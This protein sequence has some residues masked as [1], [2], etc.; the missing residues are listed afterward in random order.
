LW[1]IS[2]KKKALSR[3]G[4]SAGSVGGVE[5]ATG[6]A[7]RTVRSRSEKETESKTEHQEEEM[8]EAFTMDG[9]D[10]YRRRRGST[11]GRRCVRFKRTSAG[12]RCAKFSG[13]RRK[14]RSRRS[15]RGLKGV[16]VLPRGS[17][18]E[19]YR[20][21]PSGKR[22][23]VKYKVPRDWQM[24]YRPVRGR[25]GYKPLRRYGY[26]G[27]VPRAGMKPGG[28]AMQSRKAI[29]S[30][31]KAGYY[32]TPYSGLGRSRRGRK[33]VRFKR[34]PAGRR[35]AKFSGTAKRRK[36]TRRRGSTAG[37]KCV[38]FKRTSAGRRC[39]KFGTGRKSPARRR[40]RSSKGRRCVRFK[41]T[42]AGRRCAKFN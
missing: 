41:R 24:L 34:T 14:T 2:I 16:G 4:G 15:T 18:C 9:F 5:S 17:V 39:A 11:K 33:C 19:R 29:S 3:V 10:G 35:C 8:I 20:K 36:S 40:R 31:R 27:K 13:S 38:R 1:A 22:R 26:L 7:K 42:S 23:C 25:P 6:A 12:R 21:G 37:R 32:L 30:R 28:R